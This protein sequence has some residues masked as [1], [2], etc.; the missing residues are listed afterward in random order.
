[1]LQCWL[2]I[3]SF[4]DLEMQIKQEGIKLVVLVSLGNSQLNFTENC[5][6]EHRDRKKPFLTI[7]VYSMEPVDF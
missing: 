4:W 7:T 2:L 5:L 3:K 1:M 6:N